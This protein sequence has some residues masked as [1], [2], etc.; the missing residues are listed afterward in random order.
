M[1]LH[2]RG[3][4]IAHELHQYIPHILESA[5]SLMTTFPAGMKNKASEPL[6]AD[7]GPTSGKG[8][9]EQVNNDGREVLESK[10]AGTSGHLT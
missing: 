10:Y 3:F 2:V 1:V 7:Y 6:P 9:C 5:L 8:F 4:R